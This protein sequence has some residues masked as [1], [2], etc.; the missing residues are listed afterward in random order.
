MW[1]EGQPRIV[2][3]GFWVKWSL[4]YVRIESNFLKEVGGIESN[5]VWFPI[6]ILCY[7]NGD[8]LDRSY[9]ILFFRLHR[10]Y[11]LD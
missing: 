10:L 5:V 11:V 9:C 6:A 3:I 8:I 2:K 1:K 7:L 4:L